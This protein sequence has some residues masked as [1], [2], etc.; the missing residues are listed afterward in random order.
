MAYKITAICDRCKKE[1]TQNSQFFSNQSGEFQTI[2]LKIGQ[3]ECKD[4]LFC[5]DCRKA[6]GLVKDET[7][8]PPAIESIEDR[9]FN[10]IA[11]IV[12]EN[13]PQG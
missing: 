2:R 6:L 11:E 10:C 7:E 1:K 4:Y 5:L 9:L 13:M 8:K 12:A 3:Y